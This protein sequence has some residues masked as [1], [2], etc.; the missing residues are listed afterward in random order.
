[1]KEIKD[2]FLSV[3]DFRIIQKVMLGD[4]F[5]WYYNKSINGGDDTRPEDKT[6]S[7]QFTHTFYHSHGASSD[8]FR[9]LEPLFKK[10][11]PV[12]LLRIKANLGPRTEK[13][14]ESDLHCDGEYDWGRRDGVEGWYTSIFYLNTNNGYTHFEDGSKVKSRENRLVTFPCSM[15]HGGSSCTDKNTRVVLNMNYIK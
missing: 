15:M 14:L 5:S 4:E 13:I 7:Y 12:S 9:L 10:V 6:G 3:S 1:M 11:K 8:C 2:D